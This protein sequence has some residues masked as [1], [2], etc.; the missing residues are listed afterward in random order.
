[1]L[2]Y[3]NDDVDDLIAKFGQQHSLSLVKQQKLKE[4]LINQL[5]SGVITAIR[6]D[7]ENEDNS[8]VSQVQNNLATS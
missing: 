1:M 7:Q 3:E 8:F 4:V 5:K 6:E 2:V